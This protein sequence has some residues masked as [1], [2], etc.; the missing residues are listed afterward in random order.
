MN[1][2]RNKIIET[3][4]DE[5]LTFLNKT[6]AKYHTLLVELDGN[7]I[8]SWS[9]YILA[10]ESGFHFPSSCLDSMDRYLD[11]ITDLGWFDYDAFL[12]LIKN[13]GSFLQ[14]DTELKEELLSDF[15]E[16]IL[17]FWESEVEQV[18]AGGVRKY[19]TVV[20]VN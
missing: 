12:I 3:S 11:W 5:Y 9:D 15:R 6:K 10:I 8:G 16:I 17:P 7:A 4:E 20:L 1:S 14:N 18:V 13:A 19:F 2:F